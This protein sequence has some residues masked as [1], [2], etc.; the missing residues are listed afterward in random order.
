MLPVAEAKAVVVGPSTKIDD[1]AQ[2]D[3]TYR[4]RLAPLQ[5]SRT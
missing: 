3:Q 5:K 1:D 2:D 4:W